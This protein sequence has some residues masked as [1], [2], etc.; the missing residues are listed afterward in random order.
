[1]PAP[2][3]NKFWKVRSSHGRSPIFAEPDEL[4][5]GAEQYFDWVEENPLQSEEL[6]KFQGVATKAT[7]S[8]MRAMTID[9]LCIFL[10][11]AE[12]TW[13]NYCKKEDFLGV[14]TRIKK[15]IRTQKF[16]G[17]AA[18]MLNPNIIARDLGLRDKSDITSDGK[19]LKQSIPLVLKDGKSYD[20]LKEEL[21][22]E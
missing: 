13:D 22:P 7:V 16:T 9:G 17:A 14:T 1:M 20:D 21:K 12:S 19:E 4:W 6:V 5:D 3:G 8:K 15:I 10:D 18:D 11:I 2:K